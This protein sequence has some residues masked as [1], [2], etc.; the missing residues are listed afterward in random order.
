VINSLSCQL[1]GT[2]SPLSFWCI[3]IYNLTAKLYL[4]NDYTCILLFFSGICFSFLCR[5]A[6]D[7]QKGTKYLQIVLRETVGI[8]TLNEIRLSLYDKITVLLA[9]IQ[10][11]WS[12]F[13]LREGYC[14][15]LPKNFPEYFNII[16]SSSWHNLFIVVGVWSYRN[17]RV[18]C[19]SVCRLPESNTAINLCH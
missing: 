3:N 14:V 4:T 6:C 8:N 13:R 17:P 7:R 15:I 1:H 19:R 18:A 2:E 9:V 5:L 12:A 16:V 10:G 11:G